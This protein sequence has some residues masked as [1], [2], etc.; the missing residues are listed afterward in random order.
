MDVAHGETHN[1]NQVQIWDCK[2]WELDQRFS[3]TQSLE[4]Q[5]GAGQIRWSR[6]PTKCVQ[7]TKDGRALEL[8]DCMDS[9]HQ[10]FHMD[11][12]TMGKGHIHWSY[13]PNLCFDVQDG[14]MFNGNKIQ[15]YTCNDDTLNQRWFTM[16]PGGGKPYNGCRAAVLDEINDIHVPQLSEQQCINAC[17]TQN[18]GCAVYRTSD[19]KC[20]VKEHCPDQPEALPALFPVEEC[21]HKVFRPGIM[22]GQHQGGV[23]PGQSPCGLPPGASSGE[24]TSLHGWRLL[25]LT[26]PAWWGLLA[27]VMLFSCC[28]WYFCCRK[29]C[30]P[31]F[32]LIRPPPSQRGLGPIKRFEEIIEAPP[33]A[34]RVITPLKNAELWRPC[35]LA[36]TFRSK[37]SSEEHQFNFESH[38]LG[39]TFKLTAPIVINGFTDDGEGRELGVKEGMTLVA[40]G[41]EEPFEVFGEKHDVTNLSYRDIW[42]L[43]KTAAHHIPL[44]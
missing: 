36:L 42:E 2:D 23:P 21:L 7:V 38:P 4:T 43:L 31:R 29:L 10:Q 16:L 27:A 28:V 35:H 14:M 37:D 39:L 8:W 18:C 1:G 11:A 26:P 6:H 40:V 22:P 17:K 33:Y 44:G 15:L 41:S 5:S 19:A 32:E 30:T 13:N 3:I 20:L 24:C 25:Y 12:P 34:A 9:V